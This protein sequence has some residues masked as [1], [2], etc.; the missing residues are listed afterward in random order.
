MKRLLIACVL[1]ASFVLS[2]CF[3]PKIDLSGLDNLIRVDKK[4]GD[5]HEKKDKEKESKKKDGN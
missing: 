5:K 2:G 3:S 1:G 4:N